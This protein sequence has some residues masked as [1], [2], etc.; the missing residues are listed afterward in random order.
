MSP[1]LKEYIEKLPIHTFLLSTGTH[2]IGRRQ[3]A[4]VMSVHINAVLSMETVFDDDNI[5][6]KV[7]VPL[8]P[9]TFEET[10]ILYRNHVVLENL[11]SFDLKKSY[12]DFLLSLKLNDFQSSQSLTSNN[13]ENTNQ[14]P[15]S[16]RWKG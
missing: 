13:L 15:N 14:F 3:G 8:T 5:F 11:A 7:F 9:K 4:D 1:A 10:T 12:C 2:I 6:N 16:D